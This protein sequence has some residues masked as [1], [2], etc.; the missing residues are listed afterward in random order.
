MANYLTFSSPNSFTL[1]TKFSIK[2]WDGILEYSTDASTWKVWDGV[3][4]LLANDGKLY[5][6]GTG[7]TKITAGTMVIGNVAY[8]HAWILNGSNIACR[9]NIENL[10]DYKSVA[11]GE[12]PIMAARCFE[13]MFWDCT[14]LTEAPELPATTLSG[15]CYDSMFYGCTALTKA[16]EL[17]ATTLSAF[18]YQFMFQGCT[19][20]TEAPELPATT[21]AVHCY[22]SMFDGC[23]ALTEA[24]E[25]PATT[26]A[27]SCYWFMFQDCTELTKAPELPATTLADSC[28]FGMFER[29]TALTEAPE[30][31]AT[32]L[33]ALCYNSMFYGCTSLKSLPDLPATTLP[34]SCYF[35]MFAGCSQIRVFHT[36]TAEYQIPYRIPAS[37]VGTESDSVYYPTTSMFSATRGTIDSPN[38]NTTYYYVSDA[39]VPEIQESLT[40]LTFSSPSDFTLGTAGTWDGVLECSTDAINWDI[41]KAAAESVTSRNGKL[42]IRGVGNTRLCSGPVSY[43]RWLFYNSGDSITCTGNIENLLDF[44]TVAKGGHPPMAEGCFNYLFYGN[45]VLISAP[46]LPA[47]TLS[48]R[49]YFNLFFGTGIVKAPELPATTLA[50]QCYFGMFE[51]CDKLT[52]PPELPATNL[53][54]ECYKHMFQN[55]TNLTSLPSLPATSLKQDCYAYMFRGCTKIL[56]SATKT[57]EYQIPYR[58]PLSGT[59]TTALNALTDMFDNT[60]GTFSGTPEI[61]KTY[62]IGA[63][64]SLKTLIA[65]NGATVEMAEGQTATLICAGKKMKTDV[66]II[67]AFSVDF[68]YGD[69][70]NTAEPGDTAT[71]KCAGKKMATDVVI[72]STPISSNF[73][74]ADGS[75]LITSDGKIFEV[76]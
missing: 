76:K 13:G 49:C 11:K 8:H 3:T 27:D 68:T 50:F 21:L 28:Y 72:I 54:D 67:P 47:T 43:A 48:K 34:D 20:L 31:P 2:K 58:I 51:R 14:A 69:M 35:A 55:C 18:C 4:T 25:L 6:R 64:K 12:H 39:A 41:W 17:P 23:T 46:S 45:A 75:V 37:G 15:S 57:S 62:Y 29:C 71:L 24:P 10:L 26:L 7:N 73:V 16:P 36:Q 22:D 63:G 65:Y 30:L 59:A 1:A 53:A 32:T 40:Y 44:I 70:K 5:L 66:V 9:G 19:A 52:I 60:G 38:I 61:N 74:L 33:A 42:Y 56:I